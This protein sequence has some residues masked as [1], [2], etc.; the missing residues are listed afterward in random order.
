[1]V[2]VCG[3]LGL[4]FRMT[5]TRTLKIKETDRILALQAEMKKLGIVLDADRKGDRISWDGRKRTDPSAPAQIRTYQDH[6][7]AMSFTPAALLFPGLIIEDPD[8]VNK[9]YPGFW[10]DL[11]HVGFRID[12]LD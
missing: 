9:S 6:R 11:Q 2:V 1:M 5:G 10:G 3:L 4:P 8:V 12:Q 7:M